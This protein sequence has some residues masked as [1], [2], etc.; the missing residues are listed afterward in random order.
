MAFLVLAHGG[1][2]AYSWV[3]DRRLPR[4]AVILLGA[5]VL[6]AIVVAAAPGNG[7]R[8]AHF[9]MRHDVLRTIGYSAAQTARFGGLAVISFPIMILSL[10]MSSIRRAAIAMGIIRP[11]V[12]PLN[13]WLV[14][15]LPFLCLFVA[16]V[17]TYWPTGLLG[18]HRTVNMGL[19]YCVI[20]WFFATVVW[21]QV[22]LQPRNIGG[23]E[24]L[25]RWPWS[26]VIIAVSLLVTGNGMELTRELCDGTLARYD[27]AM[28]ARYEA[29]RTSPDGELVLP[30]VQWPKSLK[31]VPLDTSSMNW[32]NLSMADYFER[33]GLRLMEPP[34]LRR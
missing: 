6:C 18:Q 2:L 14:L 34:P 32:M 4:A 31:V 27:G 20:A 9:A 26:V 30:P 24:G 15:A 19:F 7:T 21:D 3:K 13:K 11:F 29:I 16:M 28:H 23:E 5:S 17:V 25:M 1:L 22:V 8:G 33:A 12:A 10:T